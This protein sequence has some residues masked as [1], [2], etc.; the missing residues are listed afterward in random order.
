V[1]AGVVARGRL[2]LG[3]ALTSVLCLPF[4]TQDI[5]FIITLSLCLVAN[6]PQAGIFDRLFL[7]I[8]LVVLFVIFLVIGFGTGHQSCGVLLLVELIARIFF[9]TLQTGPVAITLE[10][11]DSLL[12]ATIGLF[13]GVPSSIQLNPQAFLVGVVVGSRVLQ[14]RPLRIQE[15]TVRSGVLASNRDDSPDSAGVVGEVVVVLDAAD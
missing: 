2:V 4:Q 15:S 9:R 14:A 1:A 3:H 12:L 8:L 13:K 11:D 6:E 5:K 10:L 7:V